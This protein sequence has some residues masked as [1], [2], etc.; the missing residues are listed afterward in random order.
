MEHHKGARII[1]IAPQGKDLSYIRENINVVVEDVSRRITLDEYV[2]LQVQVLKRL[3]GITV[4]ERVDTSI[5]GKRA[6]RFSYV[7]AIKDFGY[8]AIVHTLQRNHSFF[9][10]T[11]ISQI[12]NYNNFE[13][14]F[15]ASST[16][17]RFE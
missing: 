8:R 6:V 1:A 7:Y 14:I 9:V 4:L 10:I 13:K 12:N 3:E 2:D 11:G 16:G 15:L 5:A 17:F